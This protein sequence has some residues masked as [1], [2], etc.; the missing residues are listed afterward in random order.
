M[1]SRPL[2]LPLH[3]LTLHSRS[4]PPAQFFPASCLLPFMFLGSSDPKG[5]QFN[6][7]F[8]PSLHFLSPSQRW[9]HHPPSSHRTE[10]QEP[11]LSPS[12]TPLS[13]NLLPTLAKP[14][15]SQ[16]PEL[17]TGFCCQAFVQAVPSAKNTPPSPL[18]LEDSSDIGSGSPSW[19][20]H[21][22]WRSLSRSPLKV[23]IQAST[24]PLLPS[25]Q[26]S[27]PPGS[28]PDPIPPPP[29]YQ[30]LEGISLLCKYGHSCPR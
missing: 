28:Y 23:Q 6:S 9:Y 27:S 16:L 24:F 19:S 30:L 18:L 12:L 17:Q 3:L 1:V 5:P 22:W 20:P 2:S 14:H 15:H 7:T 10:T 4:V 13:P 21:S 26:V 11:S 29:P 8:S 25:T